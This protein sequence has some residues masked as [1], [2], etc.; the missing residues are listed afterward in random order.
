MLVKGIAIGVCAGA[1]IGVAGVE[2]FSD[3]SG[4]AP[5]QGFVG[6]PGA[7]IRL[8][9]FMRPHPAKMVPAPRPAKRS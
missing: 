2:H 8:L 3:G 7:D 5:Q 4:P 6:P 1:L 9:P